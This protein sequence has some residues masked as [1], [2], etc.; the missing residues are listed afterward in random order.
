MVKN[1]ETDLR[2]NIGFNKQ[3]V[4]KIHFIGIGG[5][6]MS[7]IAEVLASENY[8]I[9]GSDLTYSPR[10]SALE[11]LGI[12]INISHEEKNIKDASVVVVS[13]AIDK[14]NIELK[15]AIK[16]QIPV[17]SRAQMLAELMRFRDSVVISGTHGKTTTTSLIATSLADA[18]LDPTF[19]I[20]GLLKSLGTH[21]KLGQ[22]N[23][24]VA[25]A[26]ESDAS[27]LNFKPM[28]AV[29]TNI[30]K[31]HMQTYDNN[32]ANLKQSFLNFLHNLPFY[33]L[34]I[35]C[36]DDPVLREIK[37]KIKRQTITYGF[38]KDADLMAYDYQQNNYCS[39]FSLVFKKDKKII[40]DKKNM[41]L[42]M[43]G[44]HNVLNALAAV[45]VCLDKN[46]SVDNISKSLSSFSGIARR[47]DVYK[48]ICFRDKKITLI[49]D[50]GHHPKE[51]EE[52][53]K[54]I[55]EQSQ[56]SRLV[57]VFQ[58]HRYS[59]T[60]E[61]FSDFID[62]LEKVDLLF[63]TCVY[64]AG[65]KP[66]KGATSLDLINYLKN[67]NPQQ[68]AYLLDLSSLKANLKNH[69]LDGD[70]LLMQGAGS[71][72]QQAKDLLTSFFEQNI[73]LGEKV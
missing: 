25:E 14:E 48:N 42:N 54:T 34:A 1:S 11:K 40:F 66:I 51:L 16:M 33:G 63:L 68:K 2:S 17:L 44:R 9:S 7:G 53:F 35:L 10:I 22:S 73:I 36:M 47:F 59:R 69:L 4:K 64:P 13:S 61:L 30:E 12:Q 71:I 28:V 49:D 56:N 60:K 57:V 45:A 24:F 50:Y 39:Y 38:H 29:I 20:G 21:A 67:K 55:K 32:F 72:G 15:H 52:T 6:G 23:Y 5:S 62:V 46:I 3:R 31:D 19:V 27:F 18:G 37:P 65:E 8:T 58:P 26:D 43:P 41:I 70:I